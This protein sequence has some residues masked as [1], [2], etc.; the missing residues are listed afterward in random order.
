QLPILPGWPFTDFKVQG[1]LL[2]PVI[3]DLAGARSL[4]SICVMLSRA[5]SLH[6]VAIL[7]WLSSKT[8][9]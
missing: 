9:N 3:V 8:L 5:S 4:Q 2:S 1:N 6:N 7:R